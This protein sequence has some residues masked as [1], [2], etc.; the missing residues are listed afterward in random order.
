M[1]TD[2]GQD[3]LHDGDLIR[4]CDVEFSFHAEDDSSGL[5]PAQSAKRRWIFVRRGVG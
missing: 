2:Y 3:T 1:G 4:I 5:I